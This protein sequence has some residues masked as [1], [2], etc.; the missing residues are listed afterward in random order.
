[1]GMRSSSILMLLG[2][3]ASVSML[4]NCRHT[5]KRSCA[6]SIP[7][8]AVYVDEFKDQYCVYCSAY[9]QNWYDCAVFEA[10][11]GNVLFSHRLALQGGGT[12]EPHRRSEYVNVYGAHHEIMLTSGRKLVH[13]EP[14]R[15]SSVP[16]DA[17]WVN[18]YGCSAFLE[19]RTDGEKDVLQ[20]S[21]YDDISGE[22]LFA[23]R[24]SGSRPES[25]TGL[26]EMMHPRCITSRDGRSVLG[27][28]R[29][30]STTGGVERAL[31]A[32]PE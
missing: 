29:G 27:A 15:P 7:R 8:G 13:L 20:C 1:M 4:A 30:S 14:P 12:F 25:R 21:G 28:R 17:I 18:E 11:S 31:D 32:A 6:G 23:E 9:T 16:S 19:C 22:V 3:G 26:L 5:D 10:S 2:I 24:H